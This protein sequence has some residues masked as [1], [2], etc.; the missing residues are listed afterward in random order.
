LT[1]IGLGFTLATAATA[2]AVEGAAAAEY[3]QLKRTCA[4]PAGPGCRNGSIGSLSVEINAAAG[5]FI[6]AGM[7]AAAEL[8]V[9][10]VESRRA[11]PR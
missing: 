1:F 2:G 9:A 7:L 4:P 5:L 6:V 3:Q 10:I 11:R 8:A